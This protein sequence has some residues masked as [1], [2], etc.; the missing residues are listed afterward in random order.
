[1]SIQQKE[2]VI[3][4]WRKLLNERLHTVYSTVSIVRVIKTDNDRQGKHQKS[5]RGE[6]HTDFCNYKT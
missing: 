3:G 5:E 4:T 6:M 1:M 2:K